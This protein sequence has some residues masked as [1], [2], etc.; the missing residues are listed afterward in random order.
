MKNELAFE[1][2]QPY[3]QGHR[4]SAKEAENLNQL[5]TDKVRDK[6]I[7]MAA[8]LGEDFPDLQQVLQKVADEY[9]FKKCRKKK[10]SPQEEQV[11]MKKKV[12]E[13]KDEEILQDIGSQMFSD[14]RKIAKQQDR[15]V[16]QVEKDL[17]SRR[18]NAKNLISTITK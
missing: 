14:L 16:A 11:W 13:K 3:E 10:F 1:I 12:A 9:S 7:R 8:H 5:F 18:E 4:L 17:R 2:A 15:T 6:L